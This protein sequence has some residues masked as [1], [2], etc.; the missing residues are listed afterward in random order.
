VRRT[1]DLNRLAAAVRSVDVV[2]DRSGRAIDLA[3]PVRREAAL[4]L[5]KVDHPAA[6][7]LLL[8]VLKDRDERVRVAAIRSLRERAD[9]KVL[10]AL[11]AGVASWPV[12]PYEAA[13]VEALELLCGQQVDGLVEEYWS[14]LAVHRAGDELGSEDEQ[15]LRRLIA[16][17]SSPDATARFVGRAV[18]AL[19]QGDALTALAEQALAWFPAESIA[20]LIDSLR[21]PKRRRHAARA[22]GATRDARALETLVALLQ[23]CDDAVRETAACALGRLKDPRSVG[24]LVQAASDPSYAVREAALEALDALGTVAVITVL[25]DERPR[26]RVSAPWQPTVSALE[27]ARAGT[28]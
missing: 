4:T 13:R 7:D 5:A 26:G 15:A 22:L 3:V 8:G 23:D 6:V 17:A 18:A 1:A 14:A 12:P 24:P 10:R 2:T 20:P 25:Q 11:A 19:G 27:A 16:A 9:M 28:D 21:E